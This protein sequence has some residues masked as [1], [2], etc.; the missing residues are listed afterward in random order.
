MGQI[1]LE[2]ILLKCF[3][4]AAAFVLAFFLTTNVANAQS[5][6]LGEFSR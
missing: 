5:R 1:R 6:C 4:A 2:G 3:I